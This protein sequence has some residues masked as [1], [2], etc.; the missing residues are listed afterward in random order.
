MKSDTINNSTQVHISQKIIATCPMSH[1]VYT[2]HRFLT[3]LEV[4]C[5]I[6]ELKWDLTYM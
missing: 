6:T 4:N 1:W 5:Q 2:Q 3:A